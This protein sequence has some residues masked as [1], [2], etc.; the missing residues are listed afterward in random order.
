MPSIVAIESGA[1]ARVEYRGIVYENARFVEG[2]WYN[3]DSQGVVSQFRLQ[4]YV[5]VLTLR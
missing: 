5:S 4:E 1:R 3:I 2:V